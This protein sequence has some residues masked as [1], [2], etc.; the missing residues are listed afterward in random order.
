MQIECGWRYFRID[1]RWRPN[2]W[3]WGLYRVWYDGPHAALH[4]GPIIFSTGA[5]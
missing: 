2:K 4:F 5:K 3:L 1:W